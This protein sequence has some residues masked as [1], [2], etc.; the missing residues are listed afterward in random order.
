MVL[1]AVDLI[2]FNGGKSSSKVKADSWL[3]ALDANS[4]S[5]S[6][7]G[8]MITARRGHMLGM[9]GGNLVVC[10]GVSSTGD[11]IDNCE[12]FD[13]GL[14]NWVQVAATL[15]EKKSFFPSVQLD[16]NRIWMGRKNHI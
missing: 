9:S 13:K 12:E 7:P 15:E 8:D 16:D 3:I 1:L 4:S 5:C 2:V 14:G 6:P 11:K 10:G